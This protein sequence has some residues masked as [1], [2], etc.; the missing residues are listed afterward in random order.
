MYV[1]I[2][3]YINISSHQFAATCY[4]SFFKRLA[5]FRLHRP[6]SALW[7]VCS[8]L[9][10]VSSVRFTW[11]IP[12]ACAWCFTI[13]RYR[14]SDSSGNSAGHFDNTS[15]CCWCLLFIQIARQELNSIDDWWFGMWNGCQ[16]R[17]LFISW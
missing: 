3:S 4:S 5:Y 13:V 10:W 16:C 6:T 1:S 11:G 7:N 2:D 8:H 12:L 15:M 14:K 17:W 9:V